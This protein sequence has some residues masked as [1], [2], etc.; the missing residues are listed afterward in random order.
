MKSPRLKFAVQH[1]VGDSRWTPAIISPAATTRFAV[2]AEQGGFDAIAFTDHPAPSSRWVESGGEGVA[3]LFTSLGFCAAVTTRISLL[4]YVLLPTYRNPF[5]TAHQAATLDHLS[6]GRLILGLGTGYLK[7]EFHA[8]GVDPDNRR[9]RFAE[10]MAVCKEVWAGRDVTIEGHGFSAR[11]VR[12]VPSAYQQPHP[13]IWLHGNT[14]W[15]T[16][17]VVREAQ[18]WMGMIVGE[19]RTPTLRTTPIPTLDAFFARVDDVRARCAAIGRDPVMLEIVNSGIWRMLDVRDGL[20]AEQM[21][22]D[23]GRLLEHGV[24]WVAFNICGDDPDASIDTLQWFS[25]EIIAR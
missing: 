4:T 20:D 2:T 7:S 16:D 11:G 17:W 1:G 3:D 22:D 15:A 6:E 25:D 19:D 18:G 12:S 5:V 8:L 9:Q 24:D 13:P 10:A 21:R 23:V 14:S